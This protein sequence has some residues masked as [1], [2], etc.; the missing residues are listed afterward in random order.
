[1][2]DW[3][4]VTPAG[5]VPRE[6]LKY[7]E[8]KG[9]SPSFTYKDVWGEEHA[10]AF[11]VAGAMRLDLIH[12]LKT[13]LAK[14]LEDGQTFREWKRDLVPVLEEHGWLGKDVTVQDPA[15]GRERT[16]EVGPRRLAL[17]FETNMRTARAVGQWQRIQRTKDVL[18]YL[19]YN[20]GP[21]ARHRPA[22]AAVEGVM[23]PVDDPFW[24]S[25]MTPNGYRCKCWVRAMTVDAV[26]AAGGVSDVPTDGPA[27]EGWDHNPGTS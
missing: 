15:D 22:H 11:A 10:R 18:P 9:L 4:T 6:A 2:A 21:S 14:A 23:L 7:W 1:M 26:D 3:D 12:D 16:I 17:V 5:P 19:Q 13:S 24:D 8:S 25:H 27:D 20:L